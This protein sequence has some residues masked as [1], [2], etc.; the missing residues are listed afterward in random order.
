[1]RVRLV[2]LLVL[3]TYCVAAQ[4]LDIYNGCPMEGEVSQNNSPARIQQ[5]EALNRLKNRYTFPTAADYNNSVTLEAMLANEGKPDRNKFNVNQAATIEGF[6]VYAAK[7]GSKETCNCKSTSTYFT[8][9]HIEIA[10]TPDEPK[11]G[12]T[13]T[14]EITPRLRELMRQQGID[15]THGEIQN[16]VGK[17][18]R[19]SG[20]LFYDT[21]HEKDACSYN[22]EKCGDVPGYNRHTCWEI[23]PVTGFED[24]TEE[25]LHTNARVN[26]D[27]GEE[28]LVFSSSPP[29]VIARTSIAKPLQPME[30]LILIMLGG[31]VGTVGQ[32]L[33]VIIGLKKAADSGEAPDYK[34]TTLS[35]VLA[36]AVGGVAGVLA[37][38][39]MTDLETIDKSTLLAFLTAGYAGT[40]FIEGFISK[41]KVTPS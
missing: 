28:R 36:F 14:V 15:W 8:D 16:Y 17:K 25:Y 33:R 22:P 11:D 27:A 2:L 35:L 4:N 1:M 12:K 18:V 29:P 40:D 26:T 38:I 21:E 37:A 30:Y 9:Q 20:W 32:L 10:L 5:L 24:I 23:H 7:K 19:I 31:I 34:R 41:H 13:I 3:L 39:N 6:I